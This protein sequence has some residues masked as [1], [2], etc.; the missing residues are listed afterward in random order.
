MLEFRESR[1]W[2]VRY[3]FFTRQFEDA[4]LNGKDRLDRDIDSITGATLSVHAV[5]RVARVALI[6]HDTVAAP[7]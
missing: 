5:T 2:E 1:G 4:R 3:P 6:M 7:G